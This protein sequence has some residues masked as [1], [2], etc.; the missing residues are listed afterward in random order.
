MSQMKTRCQFCLLEQDFLKLI[1]FGSFRSVPSFGINSSVN[2]G[3]PFRV[4]S[5]EFFGNG[6]PLPTLLNNE[7]CPLSF[8][9]DLS[10]PFLFPHLSV[11][12]PFSSSLSLL[13]LLL[14]LSLHLNTLISLLFSLSPYPFLLSF[15]SSLTHLRSSL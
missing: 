15:P 8:S 9:H 11:L 13:A 3:M 2:L 10:P 7:L 1:F 5:A 12:I 14:S 4:Y 6:I